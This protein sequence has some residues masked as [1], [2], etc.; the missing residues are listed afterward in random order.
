MRP[1]WHD[2]GASET[3]APMDPSPARP[4]R[5]PSP[6]RTQ[7]W[8]AGVVLFVVIMGLAGVAAI[9]VDTGRR[10]D[11]T[12]TLP[13][14]GG[15]KPHIIPRPDE[16]HAPRNPGDRGG[17]QQSLVFGLVLAGM[18]LLA[19]LAWRSSRRARTAQA[20]APPTGGEAVGRP[21]GVPATPVPRGVRAP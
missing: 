11:R 9:S 21:G 17:W 16:G 5:Q 8:I 13:E 20:K 12:G 10:S 15:A 19:G 6:A 1:A 7:F 18:A 4:S 2:G 3:I 14:D